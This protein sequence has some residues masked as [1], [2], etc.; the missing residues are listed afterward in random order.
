MPLVEDNSSRAGVMKVSQLITVVR[1]V[2]EQSVLSVP[3]VEDVFDRLE[4]ADINEIESQQPE[5]EKARGPT[6]LLKKAPH[7]S[8][9]VSS[10]FTREKNV[11][12]IQKI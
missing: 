11:D 10:S 12:I 8:H 5:V 9:W 4:V 7:V 2:G 1:I 3:M 6:V